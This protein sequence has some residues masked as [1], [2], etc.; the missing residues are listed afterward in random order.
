MADPLKET[1]MIALPEPGEHPTP[2]RRTLDAY[3]LRGRLRLARVLWAAV[4]LKAAGADAVYCSASAQTIFHASSITTGASS[5][6]QSEA[7]VTSAT[8]ASSFE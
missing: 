5:S 4:K 6:R 8:S 3:G 1:R 2:E 7:R